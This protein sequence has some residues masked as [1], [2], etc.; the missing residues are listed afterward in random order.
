MKVKRYIEQEIELDIEGVTLLSVEEAK[1]LPEDI[2]SCGYWW[3]LRS[4]GYNDGS[5]AV[6]LHYGT[7]REHGFR[8]NRVDGAVRPAFIISSIESANLKF[9]D[10]IKIMGIE[11]TVISDKLALADEPVG[12]TYFRKD[13]KAPDANDYEKSDIKTWLEDWWCLIGGRTND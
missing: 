12:H 3:W 11:A 8:V 5:A 13:F 4:P 9:G 2:L 6:V 7:V 1:K 10:K